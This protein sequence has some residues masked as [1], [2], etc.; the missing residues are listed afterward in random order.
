MTVYPFDLIL[1]DEDGVVVVRPVTVDSV[2]KLAKIGR[3]IDE[4]CRLDLLKG[5]GLAE[6][7]GEYRAKK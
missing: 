7:F 3:E 4:R 1:G 2:L 6:T 5:R